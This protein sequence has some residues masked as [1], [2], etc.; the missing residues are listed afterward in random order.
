[1]L[2]IRNFIG[3]VGGHFFTKEGL[4]QLGGF[5]AGVGVMFVA[6]KIKGKID[7]K[8]FP[9]DFEKEKRKLNKSFE[10]LKNKLLQQ[11]DSNEA[12]KQKFE[13]E[14]IAIIHREKGIAKQ[15]KNKALRWN[16]LKWAASLMIITYAQNKYL[17]YMGNR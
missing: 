5:C 14:K 8:F 17:N 9:T 7:N 6:E 3:S 16:N 12:L 1:M 10:D 13:A 2:S 15:E 4:N 11:I